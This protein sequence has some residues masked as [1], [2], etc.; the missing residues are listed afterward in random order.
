M[1]QE[2]ENYFL[3]KKGFGAVMSYFMSPQ[4]QLG[5]LPPGQGEQRAPGTAGGFWIRGAAHS[6]EGGCLLT[7]AILPRSCSVSN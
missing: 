4:T 5:L 2:A 3:T 1:A 6:G 7:P